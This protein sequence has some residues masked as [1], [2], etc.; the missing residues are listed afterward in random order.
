MTN[1]RLRYQTIE[2]GDIDIHLCTLRNRQEFSDP[3][4]IAAQ[5]GISAASGPVFGVIWPSGLVLANFIENHAKPNTT[6]FLD[7][8]FKGY[9]VVGIELRP[10]A[11]EAF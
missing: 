11:V 7:Q 5:L 2:F 1:L 4:G 6:D 10:I 9:Q 3:K 8:L